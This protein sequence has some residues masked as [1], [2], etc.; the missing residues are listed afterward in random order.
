MAFEGDGFSMAVALFIGRISSI[1]V[2]GWR[3]EEQVDFR[4]A[5]GVYMRVTL[6]KSRRG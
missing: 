1:L 2:D 4:V 5:E 6:N 3:H